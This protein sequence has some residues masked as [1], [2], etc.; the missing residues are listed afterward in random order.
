MGFP[1]GPFF[2]WLALWLAFEL[3]FGDVSLLQGWCEKL[4]TV[5]V[6][7]KSFFFHIFAKPR[8]L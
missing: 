6:R 5:E 4:K 8:Y 2:V 3:Y 1:V 7:Q